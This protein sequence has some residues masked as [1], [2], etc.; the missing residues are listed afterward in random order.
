MRVWLIAALFALVLWQPARAQQVLTHQEFGDAAV[1][2]LQHMAPEAQL[3]RRDPLS[4]IVRRPNHEIPEFTVNFDNAYNEY[5]RDP[6]ALTEILDHFVRFAVDP[7]ENVQM[8]ERIVV[9]LRPRAMIDEF[10]AMQTA[11]AP[12]SELVWRPFAGDLIEIIAFDGAETI[13]YAMVHTLQEIGVS[14]E[15]A[16][17]I[18]PDNLPA[19]LGSLEA[20][21]VQGSENLVFVTSANGLTPSSLTNFC[22]VEGSE[23]V[24]V[25]VVDRNGYVM[26]ERNHPAAMRQLRA[27]YNELGNGG[28]MSMTPL[29][30]QG[31]RMRAVTL[32]D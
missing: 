28:S 11:D 13:Q 2:L 18:A 27:L 22:T 26:A 32:T 29:A 24:I 6:A 30:C 23:G 16:W 5:V 12:P 7:R 9:V 25:L 19:R 17:R 8:R 10:Q 4:V 14:P 15:E 3:E 31:G 20:Q 1:A 21:A